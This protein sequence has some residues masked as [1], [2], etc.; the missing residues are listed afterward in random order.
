MKAKPLILIAGLLAIS[1]CASMSKQECRVVDWRTVG[2]EDGTAGRSGD[3]ISRHRKACAAAGVTPDLDAYQ[4]GRA[5]GLREY[6]QPENGYRVGAN[7]WDYAGFCAADLAPTFIEAYQS[8]RELHAHQSRLQ[9]V[10]AR[11]SYAHNE[12]QRIDKQLTSDSLVIVDK[13]TTTEARAQA[14]LQVKQLV[15]TRQRL[16]DEIPH[17][18]DDRRRLEYELDQ[19]RNRVAYRN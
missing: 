16:R 18:E 13:N 3:T 7:G 19:Y 11:L 1:G 5:E 14:L 17:L 10:T 8:G 4:S 12:I 15:E 6:C 9:A 2:Y